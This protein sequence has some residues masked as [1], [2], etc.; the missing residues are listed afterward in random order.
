MSTI[1]SA[2]DFLPEPQRLRVKEAVRQAEAL[3]SGEIRVHLDEV[4]EEDVMDH[5]AYVFEELDMHRTQERN[6]VLI[7]VCVASHQVAVIGDQGIHAKVEAGFWQD[8]LDQVIA[9]FK[10]GRHAE[11]LCAGV[12]RV[13]ERLAQHF[14]RRSDDVNELDDDISIGR[15]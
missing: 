5:A 1:V 10:Q 3:T 9:E 2:D 6:G 4:I 13:G 14:P 12:I 15:R 7:Y 8:V 11:G